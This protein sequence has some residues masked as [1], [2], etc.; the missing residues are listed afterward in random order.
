MKRMPQKSVD[1]IL[2]DPPYNIS[3]YST[4][5]ILR[6]GKTTLNN[7]IADWDKKII[8]PIEYVD[9][10]KRII[11]PRGNIIIFA[12]YNQIGEWHKAFNEEFDTF[13]IFVWHKTNPAPKVYQAG[14]RNSCEFVI[15]LWNKGHIWNFLSQDKMHNFYECPVCTYPERLKTPFHPAQKP[16]DLINH[17]IKIASNLGGIVFDPFMGVGTTG[18]SAVLNQR[19]FVGTDISTEYVEAANSRIMSLL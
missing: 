15:F 19:K 5:N 13:Q 11:K 10:F 8:N 7:D 17:F 9:A 1:L 16:L 6:E 4:G 14:F 12:G 3:Q 2:T 18:V